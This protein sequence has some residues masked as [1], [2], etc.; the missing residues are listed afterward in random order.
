MAVL[1]TK[2]HGRVLAPGL[3]LLG[4]SLPADIAERSPLSLAWRRLDRALDEFIGKQL[5]A[6]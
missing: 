5:I 3:A 1:F 6:A 2:A 4:S